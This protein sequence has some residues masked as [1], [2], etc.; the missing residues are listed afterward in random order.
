MS[1]QDYDF[2]ATGRSTP[3]PVAPPPPPARARATF[4]DPSGRAVNQFGTPIDAPAAPAG[5]NAAPGYGAQQYAGHG[6][7]SDAAPYAPPAAYPASPAVNRLGAGYPPA[8][9]QPGAYAAPVP[10]GAYAG[11]ARPGA[12][13]AAGIVGIVVGSL[14][15]IAGLFMLFAGAWVQGSM[16]DLGGAGGLG[17]VFYFMA[18]VFVVLAALYL[19]A[20]IGTVRGRRWAAWTLLVVA[21]VALAFGLLSLFGGS[22]GSGD[23]FGLLVEGAIVVLLVL[24]TSWAWLRQRV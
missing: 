24:P 21:G 13:L 23:I 1:G 6:L 4:T 12:V 22:G 3:E 9:Y 17:G 11:E 18:V 15:A 8:G 2:F 10:P 16:G 5:P 19:V 20:G 14:V 7:T